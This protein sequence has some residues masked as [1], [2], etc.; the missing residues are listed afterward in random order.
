MNLPPLP[1]FTLP[2][3]VA[4]VGRRLPQWPPAQLLSLALNL[5]LNRIVQREDIGPLAGRQLRLRLLDA[6]LTVDFCYT[7]ERFRAQR[8]RGR[9]DLCISAALRD[10]IALALREEDADTLFFDRRLQMEGDTELGLLVK[11]A[12]DAVDWERLQEEYAPRSVLRRALH[13]G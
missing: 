4:G 13:P 12:L 1:R 3:A 6:G 7:G 11:N 9:P 2:A 10:F 5:G 8:C